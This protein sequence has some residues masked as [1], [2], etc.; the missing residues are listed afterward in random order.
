MNT[1][2]T[3]AQ[4]ETVLVSW[5]AWTPTSGASTQQQVEISMCGGAGPNPR[6]SLVYGG[7]ADDDQVT[8][9]IGVEN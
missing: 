4:S 7:S 3:K 2:V 5:G 1:S 8:R 9:F 6:Q